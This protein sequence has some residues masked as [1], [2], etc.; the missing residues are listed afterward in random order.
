VSEKNDLVRNWAVVG[1]LMSL[2]VAIISSLS[3]QLPVLDFSF[4]QET[5]NNALTPSKVSILL[6]FYSYWVL[7]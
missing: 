7:I 5:V 6:S 1:E 4:S 3:P 2:P